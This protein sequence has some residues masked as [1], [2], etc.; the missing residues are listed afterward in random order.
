[1]RKTMK[2]V[3]AIT[4]AAAMPLSMTACGTQ[5]TKTVENETNKETTSQTTANVQI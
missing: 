2:K 4:G 3:V 1:M 5:N